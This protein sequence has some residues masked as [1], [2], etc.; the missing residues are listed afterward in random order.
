MTVPRLA[1]ADHGSFQN[2]ERGKQCR[3]PMPLV[4]MRLPLRQ[5]RAVAEES[6]ASGPVPESGSSHPR[7]ERSALSGG[8]IY[9][10]TMSRTF[11][12]NS[13]SLLNLNDL[14]PMRLQFVLLPDPLH[15]GGTDLLARRHGANTPVRGILRSRV[16]R[17]FHDG[18]LA[19]FGN[20]LWPSAA[21][22]VLQDSCK[23][24]AFE[25]LAPQQHSRKRGSQI[26][27]QHVVRNPFRR[28]QDD[29]DS[30]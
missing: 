5:G 23:A 13:G 26:A 3:C 25:S 12:A 29:V 11:G 22:S 17:R 16:N 28:A 10:P 30:K 6:A 19:L 21:R 9:R 15:R 1:F 18:G 4:I 8:F 20:L 14:H 27:R 7:S 24:V 2:I